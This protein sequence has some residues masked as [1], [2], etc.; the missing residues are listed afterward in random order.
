[1]PC[2]FLLF[3]PFQGLAILGCFV[4]F[5]DDASIPVTVVF[6]AGVFAGSAL[7]L[8]SSLVSSGGGSPSSSVACILIIHCNPAH[9]LPDSQ[10]L[11]RSGTIGAEALP[12]QA[13]L[14]DPAAATPGG[15]VMDNII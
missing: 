14:F 1:M 8:L 4:A 12:G 15:L 13:L 5:F 7:P 2:A 6:F 3:L 11:A 10:T 9:R